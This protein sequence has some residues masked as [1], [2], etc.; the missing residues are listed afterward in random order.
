MLQVDLVRLRSEGRAWLDEEVPGDSPLFAGSDVR[1]AGP[2]HVEAEAQFAGADVV[3][4]GSIEG[5]VEQE[6]RR[7]LTAIEVDVADDFAVLY[8]EQLGDEEGDAELYPLPVRATKLELGE[9]VREQFLL[10]VPPFSLCRDACRGLCPQCGTD[11][12]ER[13]C[14]CETE[15]ADERWAPL[16]NLRLD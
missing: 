11:L 6:C 7:C 12:N 13:E 4:R 16:R 3:V 2:L 8:T 9:M 1:L 10:A 14:E 15:E 5:A